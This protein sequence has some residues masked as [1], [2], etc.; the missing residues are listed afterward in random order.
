MITTSQKP[1]YQYL[2]KLM[3]LPLVCIAIILFAFKYKS[4]KD[5]PA[6]ENKPTHV[7]MVQASADTSKPT[8]EIEKIFDKVQ[9]EPT[10]PGGMDK[11]R[12][13]LEKNLDA[14]IAVKNKAPKGAYTVIVQFVVHKDGFISDVR[15]LTKHGYGMEEEAM[16]V[17]KKG[18]RWIPATQHEKTV[19]AYRKQPITFVVGNDRPVTSAAAAEKNAMNEVVITSIDAT[20]KPE[21]KI[22]FPSFPGGEEAWK[23][24]LVKNIRVIVPVD[25][26]APA[27]TYKAIVEF[28]VSQDGALSD[29]KPVTNLGYGMEQEIERLLKE[30]PKWIPGVADGKKVDSWIQQP[31]TFVV[32]EET[33]KE[34]SDPFNLNPGDPDFFSRRQAAIT[35]VINKAREEGKAAY[36]HKGRTY[37]FGR[38]D[39]P[40]KNINTYIEMDGTNH[41]FILNGKPV[42]SVDEINNRYRREQIR[43]LSLISKEEARSKYNITLNGD[44]IA[45]IEA[46]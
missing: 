38:I 34:D 8:A 12:R 19:M 29:F 15:T 42:S 45:V 33:D 28:K 26:G 3:V 43:H 20:V 18:P 2:R 36:V 27:G 21:V 1:R 9:V 24:F 7:R 17:V 14:S 23:K 30:G 11:W 4:L 25:N 22:V 46:S 35:E 16:R 10:F 44:N 32:S 31:V 39:N 6:P 5:D 13:Y 41:V 40:N 37:I